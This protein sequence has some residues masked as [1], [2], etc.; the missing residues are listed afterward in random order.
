MKTLI[1]AVWL[2]LAGCAGMGPTAQVPKTIPEQIEALNLLAEHVSDGIVDLT[3][4]QFKAGQCIEP[5]KPLMPDQAIAFHADLERAHGA[6]LITGNI[7]INGVGECLG[8]ARTQAQCLAAANAL[9]IEID[10]QL[11]AKRGGQ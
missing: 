7:P 5:G 2:L 4:T 8:K 6:L 1:A 10:R 9:I 11:I 3:C